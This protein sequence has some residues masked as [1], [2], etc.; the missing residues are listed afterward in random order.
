VSAPELT[1]EAARQGL[2]LAVVLSLPFV[3]VALVVGLVVSVLQAATQVQEQTLSFAPKLVAVALTLVVLGPWLGAEVV[4][5]AAALFERIP[6]I[7]V[8]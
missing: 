8:H 1:L 6:Q 3:G 4:R 5:Y 7:G 2:I